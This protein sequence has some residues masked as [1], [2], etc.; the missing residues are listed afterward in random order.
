MNAKKIL[1]PTDFSESSDAALHF[2]SKLAAEAGALLYLVH[3]SDDSSEYL[4]GYGGFGY[5]PNMAT[6]VSQ[7]N[8]ARLEKVVPTVAHVR[9]E[10]RFL[11]GIADEEIL[12][13]AEKE[14][15]DLIVIGSHG[16]TGL[17]RLLLGSVAEA[18]VRRATCPVLTVKQPKP[19]SQRTDQPK[20]SPTKQTGPVSKH[21]LH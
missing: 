4:A 20:P 5:T 17:S 14:G 1:F 10:H 18:V 13:L 9:Y 3:V 11:S 2:A 6:E 8:K 16:R 21:S 12:A 19:E 7:E 15:V